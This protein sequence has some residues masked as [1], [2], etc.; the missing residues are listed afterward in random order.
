M[1]PMMGLLMRHIV[2]HIMRH[3]VS[4]GRL[5][6]MFG[7]RLRWGFNLEAAAI[8]KREAQSHGVAGLSDKPKQHQMIAGWL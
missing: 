4:G 8:R 6:L 1:R 2:R 5:P 7:A 3:I